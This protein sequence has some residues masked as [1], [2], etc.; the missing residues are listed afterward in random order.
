MEGA[1][2]AVVCTLNKVPYIVL[3]TIS[4]RANHNAT[5]DFQSFLPIASKQS[6]EV[7]KHLVSRLEKNV[8]ANA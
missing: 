5:V 4:D 7:V 8:P 1:S 6:L 2:V 3:R